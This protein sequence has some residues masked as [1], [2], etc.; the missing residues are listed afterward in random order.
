MSL[1]A[2]SALLGVALSGAA[3]YVLSVGVNQ[4]NVVGLEPLHYADDDAA[5]AAELFGALPDRT[6]LLGVLDQESQEAYPALAVRARPPTLRELRRAVGELQERVA[7]DQARGEPAVVMVWLVGHGVPGEDGESGFA[8]A[9]GVLTASLLERDVV[10]PLSAAH[11]VHVVV[12]A[13]HAASLIK[14]R[15]VVTRA[16]PTEVKRAWATAGLQRFSNVGVMYASNA[17]NKTFEWADIKAGLFSSLV[18]FG[19]R[20]AADV[21]ENGRITYDELA[22]FVSSAIQAVP[23]ADARPKVNWRAPALENAVPLSDRAWFGQSAAYVPEGP[24]AN[25]FHVEDAAGRWVMAAAFEQGFAPRLW[26]PVDKTLYAVTPDAQYQLAARAEGGWDTTIL[27]GGGDVKHRGALED[28]LRSGL[29]ATP[30]GPAFY[31]G[32]S[33]AAAAQ[34][35]AEPAAATQPERGASLHPALWV[36]GGLAAGALVAVLGVL[37]A[38]V[39]AGVGG[40]RYAVS[41]KERDAAW[42]L[43]TMAG[44]GGLGV[45][46]LVVMVGLGVGAAAAVAADVAF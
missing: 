25:T 44:A 17:S 45:L 21:D 30:Y 24:L 15:A 29:F 34:A 36:A 43:I 31:R 27:E 23:R 28:A 35:N 10:E 18:R 19:M 22:A 8:M 46:A 5:A 40:L 3:P 39:V 13:C 42:G 9:D 12:D 26:L 14:S 41:T 16:D 32:Y 4:P 6:W 11:R 1:L 7:A 33:A 38:G 37:G 20:G 2:A